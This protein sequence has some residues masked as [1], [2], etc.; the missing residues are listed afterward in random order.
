MVG[1]V[2]TCAVTTF[3]AFALDVFYWSV[4]P[5]LQSNFGVAPLALG[6]VFRFFDPFDIF[7]DVGETFSCLEASMPYLFISAAF[8]FILP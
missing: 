2:V 4:M 3:V 8:G 7:F 5:F 1:S 6:V